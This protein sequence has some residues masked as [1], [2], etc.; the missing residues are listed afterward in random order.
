V[1][2]K[3]FNAPEADLANNILKKAVALSSLMHR[4]SKAC[5]MVEEESDRLGVPYV[6]VI[7]PCE[8]RWNSKYLM[9]KS[10]NT[11]APA[12]VSLQEKGTDLGEK[13]EL[14]TDS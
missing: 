6:V 5:E 11:I 1:L 14:F 2:K 7:A 13:L 10:I 12:L 4:S 8:T 3:A 9:L